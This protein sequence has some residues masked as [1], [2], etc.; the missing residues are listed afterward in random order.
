MTYYGFWSP[1]KK[2]RPAKTT[3]NKT[4]NCTS[5]SQKKKIAATPSMSIVTLL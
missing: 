4:N 1:S 3:N 2:P 5:Q